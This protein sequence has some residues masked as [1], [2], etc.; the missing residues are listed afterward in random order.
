MRDAGKL[1]CL[2]C[3]LQ[4]IIRELG[5]RAVV[6]SSSTQCLQLVQALCGTLGF[7]TVRI[8]GST[9]ASKR[10]E[11]VNAFNTCNVGQVASYFVYVWPPSLL[12]AQHVAL[13]CVKLDTH[14]QV[15][16]R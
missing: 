1:S 13:L 6:C 8:D 14:M 3:L 11:I 16:Q 15:T 12:H 2:V 10:Q 5:E 7:A 9:D 4:D